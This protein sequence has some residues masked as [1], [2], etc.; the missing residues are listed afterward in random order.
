MTL[1]DLINEMFTSADLSPGIDWQE[2]PSGVT[3]SQ[4]GAPSKLP[5]EIPDE[6]RE[7]K[8]KKKKKKVK[9]QRRK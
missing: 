4:T 9:I 6:F 5:V 8:K 1:K 7:D 3:D 2:T